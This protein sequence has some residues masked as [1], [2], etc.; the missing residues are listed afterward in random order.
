MRHD[1][2]EVGRY[3]VEDAYQRNYRL[4]NGSQAFLSLFNKKMA[5]DPIPAMQ[6]GIAILLEKPI[7]LLVKNGE[8]IPDKMRKIADRIEYYE[9]EEDLEQAINNLFKEANNEQGKV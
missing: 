6:L 2:P 8:E 1:E 7:Y 5:D 9:S 3:G 4:I